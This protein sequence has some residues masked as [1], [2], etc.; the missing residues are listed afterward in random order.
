M[1][2]ASWEVHV[3]NAKE[4]DLLR[5]E[6]VDILRRPAGS[7]TVALILSILYGVI[8]TG[9]LEVI[10]NLWAIVGIS[11]LVLAI[12]ELGHVVFGVIGGLTFK[13]MTVGP[14][15]IQKKREN[16]AFEQINYGLTLEAL[17]H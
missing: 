17:Q 3:R 16:Y 5:G 10:L 13:F 2:I 1:D 15:T 7:M 9:K 8:R 4:N 11:L 14:I 12:H 6:K